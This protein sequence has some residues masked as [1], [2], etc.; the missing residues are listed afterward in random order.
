VLPWPEADT[1][2]HQDP[3]WLGADGAYSVDLGHGKVLWLFA[4]TFVATTPA[5]VRH[6]SK[7]IRN[8]VAI[9]Q[10]YDPSRATMKFYW[11]ASGETPK[12]FFPEQDGVWYWPGDGV[13]VGP[14]LLVF[15][16]RTIGTST[17]IGFAGVGWDAVM[18][19]NPD[20]DPSKWKVDRIDCPQND[21]GVVI[22]SAGVLQDGN[23]V[24]AFGSHEPAVHDIYVVRWPA[25]AI[26]RGNLQSPEWWDGSK[27]RW[28][29]QRD[30]PSKPQPVFVNGTT[31]FT[32][33]YDSGLRAFVEIQTQGFDAAEI[34]MRSAPALTGPWS[35]LQVVYRPPEADLPGVFNYAAKA[36]PE[37]RGEGTDLIL[38][39]LTNAHKFSRLVEDVHL[40]YPRMLKIHRTSSP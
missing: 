28:I 9:E 15:L 31:E 2:F 30:L 13:R 5:H 33:H 37:L 39:Y 26:L 21:F 36:H 32:V 10:G 40:Y 7:M 14:V 34:A 12:S 20:D 25:L 11:H 1:L 6:E 29:A 4:D 18:V 38:T 27:S 16:M 24:Y 8:S 3:R 19:A 22:G 17:G 23:Y 35:P